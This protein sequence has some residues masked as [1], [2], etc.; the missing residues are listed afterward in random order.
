MAWV[1][2]NK[3]NGKWVYGTN[4]RITPHQQRTSYNKAM[5][6]EEEMDAI[7]EMKHRQ[8]GKDYKVVE[9]ELREVK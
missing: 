4:F 7:S 8:C 9:V 6:F 5:M 3:R 1:I 2:K